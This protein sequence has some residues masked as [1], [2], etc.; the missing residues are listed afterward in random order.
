MTEKF[1]QGLCEDTECDSGEDVR[2]LRGPKGNV[3]D[4][5][6]DCRTDWTGTLVR[7]VA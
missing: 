1:Q 2:A 4:L 3:F 6:A 7:E 5:C